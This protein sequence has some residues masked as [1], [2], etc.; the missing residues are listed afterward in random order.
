MS[1]VF[2]TSDW[3]GC[4]DV[5]KKVFDFLQPD[6]ILYFLGDAADRGPDGYALMKQLLNDKRVIYIKGNHEFFFERYT[7][8]LKENEKSFGYAEWIDGNGGW[9][10]YKTAIEDFELDKIIEKVKNLPLKKTYY[11]RAG[12]IIMLEHAGFTPNISRNKWTPWHDPLWDRGH[13]DEPWNNED[14]A[15]KKVYVVHGHTPVQYLEFMFGY[16][17]Q[18]QKTIEQMELKHKFLNDEDMEGWKPTI[19]RYCDNHKIDI[20]LCTISSNRI[21]LLDLDTF[22]E[23]YF[24]KEN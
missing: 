10:T 21:A 2:A 24:D 11:S 20:D 3:H 4:G 18:P 13:F 6:D 17:G 16:Y 19:L 15:F 12:N 1:R 5:A 14:P 7:K 9:S 23:I 22:E 8:E